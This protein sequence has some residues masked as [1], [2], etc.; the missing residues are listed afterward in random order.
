MISPLEHL[1]L[2][3]LYKLFLAGSKIPLSGVDI[4]GQILIQIAPLADWQVSFFKAM[5]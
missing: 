1:E 4:S 3:L 2:V 5:L